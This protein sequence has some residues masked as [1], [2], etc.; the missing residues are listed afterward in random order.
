[1]QK[2]DL[3]KLRTRKMKGLRKRK[4]GTDVGEQDGP[5]PKEARVAS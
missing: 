4:G 1:M 2:Q 3:S 5:A